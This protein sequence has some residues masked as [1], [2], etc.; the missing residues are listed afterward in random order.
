MPRQYGE[1]A[2]FSCLPYLL[3]AA[4]APH[5]AA[6]EEG[7]VIDLAPIMRAFAT[8]SSMADAVVVEG[9]GGFRVP[10]ND[11]EDTAHLAM[12]LR[13]PV[14]L[15]VGM[16]LGCLNHALITQEPILARGLKLAGWVANHVDSQMLR[17]REN[18]H[19]LEQR[20][21]APLLADIPHGMLDPRRI[22]FPGLLHD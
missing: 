20:I 16:R 17:S 5:I 11:A 6:D 3:R 21:A 10:L 9:V 1:G 4:V 7:V 2:A 18:V 12:A 14:I 19:A 8:L 13:L 15:V 22:E